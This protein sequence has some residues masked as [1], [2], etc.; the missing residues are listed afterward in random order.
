MKMLSE[1]NYL[2]NTLL[3]MIY[4]LGSAHE[5]FDVWIKAVPKSQY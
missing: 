3:M 1:L 4:A 2:Q 5:N